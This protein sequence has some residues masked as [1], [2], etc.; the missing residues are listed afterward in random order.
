MSNQPSNVD[1]TPLRLSRSDAVVAVLVGAVTADGI[2]RS[3][4]NSRLTEVLGSSRFG[5]GVG[6]EATAAATTRA[7]NLLADHGL[8]AVLS[9]CAEAI[10]ADLRATA[11]ALA[12]DL[13]LADG[14]L[15]TRES[16]LIDQLQ[17]TLR[18]EGNLARKVIDVLLI[19]NRASGAP[20]L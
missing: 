9:A 13:A 6:I 14:R 18:I 10:P 19:K 3:E 20:D 12:V 11:F 15:G 1:V 4:E 5:L 7:L 8:P 2:L 16:A 17:S